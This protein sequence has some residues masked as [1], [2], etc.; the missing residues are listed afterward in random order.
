MTIIIIDI[1]IDI[2]YY[3]YFS[4]DKKKRHVTVFFSIYTP[5]FQLSVRLFTILS[6]H[7]PRTRNLYSVGYNKTL[8]LK[9]KKNKEKKKKKKKEKT[10]VNRRESGERRENNTIEE[11]QE[12]VSTDISPDVFIHEIENQELPISS[13]LAI[14]VMPPNIVHLND[15]E[16]N[17][18][19]Q[20]I[21][22]RSILSTHS[23]CQSKL[24]GNS[25]RRNK[26]MRDAICLLNEMMDKLLY[27][28]FFSFFNSSCLLYIYI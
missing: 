9:T 13:Q 11:R 12:T 16:R 20:L 19:V 15:I 23:K 28:S 21:K 18:L 3:S 6:K 2:F 26:R 10:T 4:R 17:L 24:F 8:S 1:H 22:A 5:V 7:M 27:V 25:G 14:D